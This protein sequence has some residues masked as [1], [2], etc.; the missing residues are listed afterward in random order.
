MANF[1][2]AHIKTSK[3]EGGW[4]NDANDPGGETYKGIARNF[5]P[6]W[7]GWSIIDSF[8]KLPGFPS[9]L[10][11]DRL[12]PLVDK[13]FKTQFWDVMRLDEVVDQ[14]LAE[15]VY[16]TGVNL[17][18]VISVKILQRS[19]NLLNNRQKLYPDIEVDG[20]V[21]KR[22]LEVVNKHPNKRILFN[23]LNVLQGARYAELAEAKEIKEKYM[24][25]WLDKRVITK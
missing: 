11:E 13:F 25:G 2:P 23:L 12:D 18:V 15:E 3:V 21:G 8:K 19:C 17:G 22:T 6:N 14:S 4:V 9:N 24:V 20:I 16:D 10:P 7:T 5:F 1:G